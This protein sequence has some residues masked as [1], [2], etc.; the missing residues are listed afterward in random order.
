MAALRRS[1]A[2]VIQQ[3][4]GFSVNIREKEHK[5]LLDSILAVGAVLS[6]NLDVDDELLLDGNCIPQAL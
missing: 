1:C 2:D 4:T 3:K 6:T 5:F